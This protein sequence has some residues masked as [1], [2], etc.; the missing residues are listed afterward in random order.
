MRSDDDRWGAY[1]FVNNLFDKIGL[2]NKGTGASQ[3]GAD[4]VRVLAEMPRVIGLD[5][6]FRF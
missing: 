2:T 1:L 3:G 6:R 5:F 4:A